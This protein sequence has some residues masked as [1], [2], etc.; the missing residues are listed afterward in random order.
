MLRVDGADVAQWDPAP[1]A[2]GIGYLPQD[3]ELFPGTVA[4][5]IGR[6]S[7]DDREGILD[8][9]RAAH[10]TEMILRLPQ[11]F[12]TRL[13]DDGVRLSA[14]QAQRIA[15]ARAL[16]GRPRMLVLD[17]P[18]ASLDAAGEDALT[19]VLAEQRESGVTIVMVTHKPS[20]V[21]DMDYMLVLRDGGAELMGPARDVAQR[22]SLLPARRELRA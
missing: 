14:G 9:A 10:V 8:A 22:L 12:D 4:E 5:N 6:L 13:G 20:L 7:L 17:E 19:K 21:S 15:L 1:L 16:Y 2:A 18:N 11:G 3:V